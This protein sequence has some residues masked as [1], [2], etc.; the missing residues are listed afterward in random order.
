MSKPIG[1]D[2][3]QYTFLRVYFLQKWENSGCEK[4]KVP[5]LKIVFAYKNYCISLQD[6]GVPKG[7]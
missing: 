6:L 5:S 3:M 2:R 7:S 1:S 4:M